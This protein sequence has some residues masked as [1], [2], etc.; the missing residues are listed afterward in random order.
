M[1]TFN[2]TAKLLVAG[3]FLLAAVAARAEIWTTN[4]VTYSYTVV[5]GE[6]SI[7]NN[8]NVA[9][10]TSESIVEIPSTLGEEQYPVTSIGNYAFFNCTGLTSVAIPDSVTSIGYLSFFSCDALTSV[11]IPDSVASIGDL[12]F[13]KCGS[14]TSVTVPDSVFSIGNQAFCDCSGLT[15]AVIG[16]S[17]TNIK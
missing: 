10:S 8:G 12:A 16:S 6:A 17:V 9:V 14:L 1:K 3:G 13:Y 2:I 11:A 5:N 4:N 7:Y 15:N